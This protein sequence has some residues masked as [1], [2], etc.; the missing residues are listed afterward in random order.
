MHPSY[1]AR[2]GFRDEDAKYVEAFEHWASAQGWSGKQI[3]SAFSWYHERYRDGMDYPQ[4]SAS[5]TE[6]GGRQGI[7]ADQVQSAANFI[8]TAAINGPENFIPQ[9]NRADDL[10]FTQQIEAMMSGPDSDRYFADKEL[11]L[12]FYNALE[13]LNGGEN[14]GPAETAP[15]PT[16][17]TA[18]RV[19]EMELML[20]DP[21]SE[22][23]TGV[24]AKALQSEYLALLSGNEPTAPSAPAS[25]SDGGYGEFQPQV[26]TPVELNA[27]ATSLADVG[28]KL[29]GE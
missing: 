22:Y 23:F 18:K 14:A 21:K 12:A 1:R 7:T 8:G 25:T 3:D 27:P 16:R 24:N 26:S 10:K 9:S 17:A 20:R 11:Q 4:M 13:R 5:F 19:Q 29:F 28:R 15:P 6:Y 2:F